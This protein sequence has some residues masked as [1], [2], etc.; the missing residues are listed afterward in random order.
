MHAAAPMDGA[1]ALPAL[2]VDGVVND[3]D[4]DSSNIA[5]EA[6]GDATPCAQNTSAPVAR[7]SFES[8]SGAL[9]SFSRLQVGSPTC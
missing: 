7:Q 2:M 5:F 9:F 3:D 8:D 1:P 6:D 4:G